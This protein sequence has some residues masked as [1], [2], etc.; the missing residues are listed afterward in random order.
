MEEL[1]YSDIKIIQTAEKIMKQYKG[2]KAKEEMLHEILRDLYLVGKP[3]RGPVK[4]IIR[5][6]TKVGSIF[7]HN[8]KGTIEFSQDEQFIESAEVLK[9]IDDFI[10]DFLLSDDENMR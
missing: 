7:I 4:N 5:V 6:V 10:E 9:G 8:N 3:V 1:K 2:V